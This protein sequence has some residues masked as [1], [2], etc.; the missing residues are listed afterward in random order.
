[1]ATLLARAG[2]HGVCSTPKPPRPLI[3]PKPRRLPERKRMTIA[4]GILASDGLVIAAATQETYSGVFKINQGKMLGTRLGPL[5]DPLGYVTVTGAGT[6]GH[7][8][9]INQDIC[10]TV[11]QIKHPTFL[12][13]LRAIKQTVHD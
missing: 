2:W 11:G 10:D 7:L 8:D 5:D 3:P 1:M 9:A 4:L 6:A 13:V 12:S